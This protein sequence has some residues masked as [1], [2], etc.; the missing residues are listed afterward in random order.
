MLIKT[1]PCEAWIGP[2]P[3]I[4]EKVQSSDLDETRDMML[5]LCES[6]EVNGLRGPGNILWKVM[7]N[8]LKQEE[9]NAHFWWSTTGSLLATLL[10]EARYPTATQCE[11]LLFYFRIL[12]PELGPRPDPAGA[13]SQ[14]KSFMT[15]DGIPIELSWEWGLGDSSSVV[16]LSIE[17]I[18][19]E[20]GTS[21]DPLNELSTI[22]VVS[23][24]QH[25]YPDTDLRSFHHF[26]KELLTY[27]RRHGINDIASSA[28]G[29]RSRSFVAFDFGKT[30]TMLKAYFFP[31]F[32]AQDTGQS[33]LA[34][35]S[36]AIARF[37]KL[38]GLK[39]P[40]YDILSEYLQTSPEGSGLKAE[41]FSTD[42][43]S[44]VSS[45]IKI[46]LRSQS[47]SFKS[48][49]ANMTLDGKLKHDDLEKGVQELEK[50]WRLVLLPARQTNAD[51]ELPYKAHRTAGILYYYDIM[52]GRLLPIPRLYI[53]VRH[54]G[55]S[56]TAIAEGLV[57]YLK[58]RGQ[59]E[60]T[61]RYLKA[62]Q[63]A[64]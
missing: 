42:C 50:L 9:M 23:D 52:P 33:T 30:N 10:H 27:D 14:W 53:P 29:H 41:M 4:S 58:A 17:P 46:Y 45:R 47:T 22:R 26:S 55:Q 11:I 5:S 19:V 32:K 36:Q 12:V 57:R 59:D 31:I 51:V 64:R 54:Y 3:S 37:A 48:V 2:P 34:L 6:S 21:Q 13:F 38:E 61:G 56:D 40:A 25:L 16:R 49:R 28:A 1:V 35:I 7:N 15:D 44:P 24:F 60:I 18:G 43:V 20:A 39:F 63:T 62:L 8:H